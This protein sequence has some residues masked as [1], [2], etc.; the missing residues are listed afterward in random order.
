[1]QKLRS[2]HSLKSIIA[3]ARATPDQNLHFRYYNKTPNVG[4][5]LNLILATRLQDRCIYIP[6]SGCFPHILGLGSILHFATHKSI[7]WGSGFISETL[8]PQSDILSS[9]NLLALRG[10]KTKEILFP[11]NSFARNCPLGDPAILMPLI[12]APTDVPKK[13]RLG[14]IPHL[15]DC[16]CPIVKTFEGL[17][18]VLIIRPSQNPFEFILNMMTCE[19][20]ASSSLH[21][22]ILSDAYSIPNIRLK[23]SDWIIG[24]DFKF[25]DYYSTT[26][27]FGKV[28]TIDLRSRNLLRLDELHSR[29]ADNAFT[30]RYLYSKQSL[31]SAFRIGCSLV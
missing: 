7:V 28:K 17:D 14:I 20:I 2:L 23:L 21:G 11:L 16:E 6:K 10:E 26:S 18:D 15:V 9:L 30:S 13:Y 31:L 3:D 24:G 25:D 1:M 19:Y 8:M 5:D 4:D 29:V 22:L 27:G 12:F